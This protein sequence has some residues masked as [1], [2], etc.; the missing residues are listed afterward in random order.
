MGSLANRGVSTPFCDWLTVTVPEEDGPTLLDS[1]RTSILAAGGRPNV[2]GWWLG[3]GSIY[4]A[5][6]HR[7]FILSLSGGALEALRSSGEWLDFL[8]AVSGQPHRVTRLDVAYDTGEDAPEVLPLLE[9]RGHRGELRLTRKTVSPS[10]VRWQRSMG[11]CGRVSGTVYTGRRGRVRVLA[12]V[13]DK[14]AER[15]DAGK[16]DP[17]VPWTRYELELSVDG[18]TLRDAYDPA[19]LW[20]AYGSDLVGIDRPAGVPEW[21][22][23]GQGY[24]LP[25]ARE[26]SLREV[27]ERRVEQCTELD[28]LRGLAE[29]MGEGGRMALRRLLLQRV[30]LS[31]S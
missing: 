15:W 30:G 12:R 24:S 28:A 19:A 29:A 13:Y 4:A 1:V 11:P 31:E 6:N 23:H 16:G 21:E 26:R 17:G 25:P 20:W 7:V 10:A 22:P 9:A 18:M 27:M 8:S 3:E 14:R 5:P 2:K